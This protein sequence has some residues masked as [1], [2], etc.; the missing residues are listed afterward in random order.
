MVRANVVGME[1]IPIYNEC[2]IVG[3]A[4]TLGGLE[5]VV[6]EFLSNWDGIKLEN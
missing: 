5:I 2:T 6:D 3:H 4:S 1:L